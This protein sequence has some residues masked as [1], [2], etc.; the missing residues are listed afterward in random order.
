MVYVSGLKLAGLG[1]HTSPTDRR[2]PGRVSLEQLQGHPSSYTV[3]NFYVQK[4]CILAD[5]VWK[6]PGTLMV[7]FSESGS[8]KSSFLAF[9]DRN[10]KAWENRSISL[11][12]ANLQ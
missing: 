5:I 4:M 3:G 1:A 9:S 6:C 8:N 2:N 11:M 7:P 12:F 10:A